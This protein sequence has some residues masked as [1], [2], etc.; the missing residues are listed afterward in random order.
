MPD[1]ELK[2]QIA[3]VRTSDVILIS[4]AF[5]NSYRI[6]SFLFENEW[7]C[8]NDAKSFFHFGIQMLYTLYF[9]LFDQ[10]LS[11]RRTEKESFLVLLCC[12][13]AAAA[14]L[15]LK[16]KP[17]L[18]WVELSWNVAVSYGIIYRTM[19]MTKRRNNNNNNNDNVIKYEKYFIINRPLR[20]GCH[21]YFFV[22]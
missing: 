7:F 1:V 11:Q 19:T 18:S 22:V 15:N 8:D 13:A 12:C 6:I 20:F 17:M 21:F 5:L 4:R 9:S 16:L 3:W 14:Q 2:T 10:K